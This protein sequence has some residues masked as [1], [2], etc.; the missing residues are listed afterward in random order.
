M[1]MTIQ[2]ATRQQWRTLR[3]VEERVM[4]SPEPS[5]RPFT[6]G[7]NNPTLNRNVGEIQPATYLGQSSV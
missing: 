4:A 6:S 1:N 2:L 3:L 5:R 7:V